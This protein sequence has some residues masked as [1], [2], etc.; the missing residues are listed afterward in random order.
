MGPCGCE[1]LPSCRVTWVLGV[2]GRDGA[3]HQATRSWALACGALPFVIN[4]Q[5]PRPTGLPCCSKAPPPTMKLLE[6]H[7]RGCHPGA[8]EALRQLLGS[9]PGLGAAPRP[10]LPPLSVLVFFTTTRPD[11]WALLPALSAFL[12]AFGA[13]GVTRHVRGLPESSPSLGP[14]PASALLEG[15]GHP[16]A[17]RALGW[18]WSAASSRPPPVG[19]L[20]APGS[21]PELLPGPFPCPGELLLTL[22]PGASPWEPKLLGAPTG[23][24][25]PTGRSINAQGLECQRAL[26]G[27][28]EGGG[29]TPTH[30]QTSVSP[31][32]KLPRLSREGNGRPP[33][34]T[35]L[36]SAPVL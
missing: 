4:E 6:P 26:P 12:L 24:L 2:R 7:G 32:P 23:L 33:P 36:V 29:S 1:H 21:S 27:R 30:E 31:V 16:V 28:S 22:N 18:L 8:V 11:S 5:R 19:L 10:V 9:S 35:P 34:P 25:P 14:A 17:P 20:V 3:Q 13:C 15:P